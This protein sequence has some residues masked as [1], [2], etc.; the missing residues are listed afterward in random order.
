MIDVFAAFVG[1]FASFGTTAATADLL[2]NSRCSRVIA[3]L[4]TE[5]AVGKSFANGSKDSR[6][7]EGSSKNWAGP[8]ENIAWV[9]DS[10]PLN[11]HHPQQF[12]C[13]PLMKPNLLAAKD[14]RT[15]NL[16]R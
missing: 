10:R 3:I 6:T 13:F 8:L 14:R 16:G 12:L 7:Q 5:D 4:R 15:L 9:E 11:L 2:D 1:C